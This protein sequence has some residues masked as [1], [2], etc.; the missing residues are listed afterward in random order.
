MSR[1]EPYIFVSHCSADNARIL[2]VLVAL[3][4]EGIPLWLDK[5]EAQGL[6]LDRNSF[7][8][9]LKFGEKWFLGGQDALASSSGVIVFPSTSARKS[10]EVYREVGYAQ[11]QKELKGAEF[12]LYS[13]LLSP[14]DATE[15]WAIT[16]GTHAF[17]I[18]VDASNIAAPIL[19]KEGNKAL[20]T[21]TTHLR[22]HLEKVRTG[23][24][25][26]KYRNE[27]DFDYDVP[28]LADR[29]SQLDRAQ[30]SF[31]RTARPPV[32]VSYGVSDEVPSRFTSISF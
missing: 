11:S 22:A 31:K 1:E 21:L 9:C 15:E 19:T 10:G 27:P 25:P 3:L 28:Y 23:L 29:T 16:Q 32:F 5:P 18:S 4:E 17:S 8:G 7:A 26:G 13:I 6:H 2:P 12:C 30:L 14:E 20:K 24:H